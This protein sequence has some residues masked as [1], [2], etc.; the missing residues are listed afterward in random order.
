MPLILERPF[1][2]DFEAEFHALQPEQGLGEEVDVWLERLADHGFV[3]ARGIHLA[4][5]DN[6]SAIAHDPKV[7]EYCPNDRKTRFATV[8]MQRKW[9]GTETGRAA[10]GMYHPDGQRGAIDLRDLPKITAHDVTQVAHGWGGKKLNGRIVGA[11]VTTAY[12]VGSEG[13]RHARESRKSPE[14]R[15]SL[16]Y[17]LGLL[18][19]EN[20]V[21]YHG[22][23]KP[24]ISL[25]NW[26]SNDSARHLYD[27]LGFH[28]VSGVPRVYD[29]RPT[30]Y[31]AG[32]YINGY[33]VRYQRD[34]QTGLRLPERE[35]AD[36]RVFQVHDA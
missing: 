19:V 10:I 22:V 8:E 35:V 9:V 24:M 3:A 32:T 26:E 31:P 14:D 4:Q 27:V 20:L 1:P 25:E 23:P 12:R 17:P 13:S 7:V 15:F 28:E 16:G 29:V 5:A 30:L 18:V 34:E 33:E 21:R 2:T 11:D 6:L 36:W